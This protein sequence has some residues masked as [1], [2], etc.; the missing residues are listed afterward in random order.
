VTTRER[1]ARNAEIVRARLRG[2]GE[3]EIANRFGI[4]SRQ[5]R[6]VLAEHRRSRPRLD[7]IDPVEV[8]IDVLGG[9]ESLAEEL[10]LLA[11]RTRHDGV[12]L[13]AIKGRLELHRARIDLLQAAGAL[14]ADLPQLRVLRDVANVV[15][16]IMFVF[17][18]EGVP[19]RAQRRISD[20]LRGREEMPEALPHP[21]S[22]CHG[23]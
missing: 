17:A 21:S 11:E 2:L 3:V 10:A 13:G 7:D 5:V 16:T 12:R 1:A 15:D 22:N 20:V 19:E 18:D 23:G 14:P 9:Y 8:V 6:R 4:T